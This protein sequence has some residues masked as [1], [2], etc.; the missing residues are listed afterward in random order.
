MAGEDV[1]HRGLTS[2]SSGAYARLSY[3]VFRPGRGWQKEILASRNDEVPGV[4][5]RVDINPAWGGDAVDRSASY[6][7]NAIKNAVDEDG[8][9]A[10]YACEV[11]GDHGLMYGIGVFDGPEHKEWK[12]ARRPPK[13]SLS[14]TQK[15]LRAKSAIYKY[16][17]EVGF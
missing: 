9:C 8:R 6:I 15:Q 13:P 7:L 12:K 4:Y 1:D 17:D 16:D 11:R 10:L 3:T 2:E 14:K 5:V